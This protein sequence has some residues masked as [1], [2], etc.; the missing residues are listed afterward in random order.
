MIYIGMDI[1][2]KITVAVAKDIAGKEIVQGKMKNC[3]EE[4]AQ[5]LAPFN[6]EETS[7]VIES[8]SVW[9]HIYTLLESLEYKKIKLANPLKVKA[10]AHAKVKNDKVDAGM[11]ADLL[12]ANL[13]PESYVPLAETRRLR[14]VTHT[15][16][17]I[18]KQATQMMNRIHA[19]FTRRGIEMPRRTFCK[20]VVAFVKEQT[21]E[22]PVLEHYAAVLESLRERLAVIDTQ[23]HKIAN[24]KEDARL[25]MTIPGIGAIRAVSMI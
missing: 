4:M 6:P 1:H 21:K 14:E 3:K 11:L 12:R 25:L 7:I 20:Q 22:D 16:K 8:S 23:M 18:V 15:R 17:M 2:K 19:H 10:I 13:I 5:F 9:E 24:E